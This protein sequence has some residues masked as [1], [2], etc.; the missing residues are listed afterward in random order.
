MKTQITFY[1]KDN[2]IFSLYSDT[3]VNYLP[4]NIGDKFWIDFDDISPRVKTD[5]R[6]TYI[7][8][9]VETILNSHDEKRKTF[10]YEQWKVYRIDKCF[11]IPVLD[12]ENTILSIDYQLKKVFK[13]YWKFWRLYK[14]KQFWKNLIKQS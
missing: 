9:F 1:Y 13:I 10:R 4:L 11:K 3:T 5:L 8:Q 2:D 7:D 12:S 6:K 14:F